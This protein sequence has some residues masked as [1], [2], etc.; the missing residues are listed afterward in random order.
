MSFHP[1]NGP[2]ADP[3]S[4]SPAC[5]ES[6]RTPPEFP[7]RTYYGTRCLAL[8]FGHNSGRILLLRTPCPFDLSTPWPTIAPR[9]QTQSLARRDFQNRIPAPYPP[10]SRPVPTFCQW[11]PANCFARF[12]PSLCRQCPKCPASAQTAFRRS[13][14]MSCISYLI[15]SRQSAEA[16]LPF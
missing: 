5:A 14:P 10:N 3:D 12:L 1:A 2:E 7:V 11:L 16:W 4:R 8:C 15:L 6:F 13:F 9:S